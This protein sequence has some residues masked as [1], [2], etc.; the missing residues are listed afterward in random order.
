M[1]LINKFCGK[2][3]ESINVIAL[4]M[5]NCHCSKGFTK[6]LSHSNSAGKSNTLRWKRGFVSK[7]ERLA[8]FI[9]RQMA[10]GLRTLLSNG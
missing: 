4:A 7:W 8:F 2:N 5:Y 9:L 6:N 1:K 10:M 3:A